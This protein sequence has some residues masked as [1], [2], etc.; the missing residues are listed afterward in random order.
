LKYIFFPWW[1]LPIFWLGFCVFAMGHSSIF[2]HKEKKI[3]SIFLY[4]LKALNIMYHL[5]TKTLW[6]SS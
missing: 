4:I 6:E 1:D 2:G 5:W 3:G